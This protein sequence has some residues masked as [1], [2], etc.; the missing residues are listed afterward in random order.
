MILQTGGSAFG[1]VSTKSNSFSS[2]NAKASLSVIIPG[3][4]ILSPT[5][6]TVGDLIFKLIL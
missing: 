4:S 1:E 3:F 6:R 2:A 5:K